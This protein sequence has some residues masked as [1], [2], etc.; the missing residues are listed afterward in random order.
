M[1]ASSEL[2]ILRRI[3]VACAAAL[4]VAVG[5]AVL[6]TGEWIGPIGDD[7]SDPAK[8]KLPVVTRSILMPGYS[9]DEL[10]S[11][12]DLIVTGT[13]ASH[14]DSVLIEPGDGGEPLFFTDVTVDVDEVFLDRMG[15]FTVG[16]D[17]LVVRT[18]GGEGEHIEMAVEG[19]PAFDEGSRYLLFLYQLDDGTYYNAPGDH[20]YVVGVGTGAWEEADDGSFA[21]SCW[22]PDGRDRVTE[23]DVRASAADAP[24]QPPAPTSG[25]GAPF[26]RVL[27]GDEQRAYERGV[28]AAAS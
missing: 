19:A 7:I 28:L 17:E 24:E 12:S 15:R 3:I 4:A 23:A 16:A 21:S 25:E 20:Y 9:L 10:A 18:E 27:A 11:R 8:K 13:V 14:A 22:Q 1:E 26:A 5:I 2:R 6:S